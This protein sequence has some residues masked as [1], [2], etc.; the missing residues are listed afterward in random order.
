M[1]RNPHVNRLVHVSAFAA[2]LLLSGMKTPVEAQEQSEPERQSRGPKSHDMEFRAGFGCTATVVQTK[3]GTLTTTSGSY[4][5]LTSASITIPTFQ[6]GYLLATLSGESRCTGTVGAW[7]TVRML[8]VHPFWGAFAMHP[9]VG[10]NFAFDSVAGS[11]DRWESHSMQRISDG[12][13]SNP[14]LETMQ[15]DV[16]WAVFGNATFALDDWLFKV[17]FCRES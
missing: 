2:C 15:V 12:I 16:E 9:D 4:T 13:Y 8:V 10:N 6:S 3:A 1:S 17:E 14:G 7:C 5:N 11:D